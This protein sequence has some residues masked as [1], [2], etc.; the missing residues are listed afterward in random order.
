MRNL[1][2]TAAVV[3]ALVG[4]GLGGWGLRTATAPAAGESSEISTAALVTSGHQ[5]V[6]QVFVYN[7]SPWWMYMS[8]SLTGGSVTVKCELENAAGQYQT[9]GKFRLDGGY[10]IWGSPYAPDGHIIGARLVTTSGK[11][12]ATAT[13]N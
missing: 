6:G 9:V 11:I 10:G 3:V 8:V 7:H 13:L 1:L 4:A 12:L 5:M 2:T